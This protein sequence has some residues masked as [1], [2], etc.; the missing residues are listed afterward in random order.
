MF[1][2]ARRTTPLLIMFMG[3]GAVNLFCWSAVDK[4]TKKTPG[5]KGKYDVAHREAVFWRTDVW[6]PPTS[7]TTTV[8]PVSDGGVRVP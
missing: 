8:A 7:V 2:S 5:E 6:M 4:K 3:I 1:P